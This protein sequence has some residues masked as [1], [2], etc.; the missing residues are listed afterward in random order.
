MEQRIYS[1]SPYEPQAGFCRALRTGDRIVVAGTAPIS[2]DGSNAG[3]GD[4]AAQASRCF[5]I[6]IDAVRELGGHPAD[7]VRT[8]IFLVDGNDFDK[9]SVVHGEFFAPHPPVATAVVV[10]GL[11][12]PEWQVEIEVEAEVRTHVR[13]LN[14]A[15][16]N[17][18]RRNSEELFG[19]PV[20]ISRGVA[21]PVANLDGFVAYKGQKRVGLAT[22]KM[23]EAECELVTLDAFQPRDGVGSVLM[24]A[25]VKLARGENCQRLWLIT[26]NDNLDALRFY[27]RRGMRISAVYP[28]AVEEVSRKMKPSI[29]EVGQYQ[30]PLRDEVELEMVLWI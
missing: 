21:H 2:D 24:D 14:T 11:L 3:V 16:R 20:V 17:W 8:R 7:V 27:Q 4:V 13:A 22:Y 18:I 9:V 30:I 5:Q 15:D 23:M 28:G 6:A 10:A 1:G 19:A 29:P 26:T 12:D 25:V